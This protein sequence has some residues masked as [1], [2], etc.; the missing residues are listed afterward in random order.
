[1]ASVS[2]SAR[3]RSTTGTASRPELLA[4]RLLYVSGKG[5]VGKSTIA[6]ALGLAGARR[7][8]RTVVA[9]VH[10]RTDVEHVVTAAGA[11]HVSIDPEDAMEEY[12]IDQLPVRALADVLT[13]SRAFMYLAAATPGLR[14][15]LTAG[16]VWELA[17]DERRTPGA[18]PYELVV[19]DAPA[20]GHGV[21]VL[22]APR[23]FAQAAG[24]GPVA[25]QAGIID[26]M[27]SNPDATAVVAVTTAEELPVNETLALRET[28]DEQLGLRPALVVINGVRPDRFTTAEAERLAAAPETPA[29]RA[30]LKAHGIARAQRTQIARLRRALGGAVP[31]VTVPFAPGGADLPAI[32]RRLERVL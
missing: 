12:L 1:M 21:A 25:R 15:L 23:T 9:E 2:S 13:S 24:V 20:T 4:H 27:L 16:K 18:D 19:V 30:A 31:T 6:A 32:A 5:G 26:A 29:V 17:Q 8:R 14:E 11:D 22:T 10:R 7:G 28:L 3:N